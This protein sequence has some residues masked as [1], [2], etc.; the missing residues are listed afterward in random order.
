MEFQCFLETRQGLLFG[1]ALT[2]NIDFE[3]LSDVAVAFSPYARGKWTLH[4]FILSYGRVRWR[5]S[6]FGEGRV[7]V[8]AISI[9]SPI[10]LS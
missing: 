5:L 6:D 9:T 2:S 3:A 1:L 10:R 8:Q 7:T 4:V